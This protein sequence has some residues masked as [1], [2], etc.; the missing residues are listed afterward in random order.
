MEKILV[1]WS[2]GRSKGTTSLVRKTAVKTGTIAVGEKVVVCWG[3]S[4]KTYNAQVIR[5]NSA[6]A[7]ASP[8]A[9]RNVSEDQFCF[10]VADPA[11]WTAD[12]RAPE[13]QQE[14]RFPLS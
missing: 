10:K 5:L 3:K 13:V 8:A 6:Q 2:D 4:K 7:P 11:P 14:E 12:Q 9:T 1:Q